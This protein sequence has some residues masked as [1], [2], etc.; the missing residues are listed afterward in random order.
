[1]KKFLLEFVLFFVVATLAAIGFFYIN[2][3]PV[4]SNQT[5][6]PFV[7]NQGEGLSLIGKRLKQAGLIKD[8]NVFIVYAYY[9]GLNNKLQ[10]GSFQLSPSLTLPDLITKLSKGG[11]HDYWLKILPGNRVEEIASKFATSKST[12]DRDQFVHQASEFEGKLFPDSYLIPQDYSEIE[13][14]DLIQ[15]NYLSKT[16]EILSQATNQSLTPD[17]IIIL[18]SIIEREARTL[19]SKK[20]VAGILLNRLDIGMALQVDASVQ[21]AKDTLG[22]KKMG[23]NWV[24]YT[25]WQPVRSTDLDIDS[26]FNT[27]KNPG[28]PPAAIC[29]PGL[30]SL[31]A[32]AN[33]TSSEYLFYITG[34]DNQM[35]YAKTLDEHNQNIRIYLQ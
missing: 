13:I 7:I 8:Q 1:M 4:S 24:N 12:I 14:L 30:D 22:Y 18:A 20:M 21:Y 29:S 10:A 19:E 26:P 31:T 33:P 25:F 34:N 17:Q 16:T 6:Q 11:S 27:Y 9:L 15:K 28:L 2:L 3:S 23:D 32:A 5:T 35:H